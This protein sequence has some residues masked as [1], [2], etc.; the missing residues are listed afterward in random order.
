MSHFHLFNSKFAHAQD[1]WVIKVHDHEQ[2][3]A[4]WFQLN[5]IQTNNSDEQFVFSASYFNALNPAKENRQLSQRFP[6]SRCTFHFSEGEGFR[7]SSEAISMSDHSCSG[8]ISTFHDVMKWNI[9]WFADPDT[10]FQYFSPRSFYQRKHP[11]LKF[12]TPNPLLRAEGKISVGELDINL[13]NVPGIQSHLWGD[14]KMNELTWLQCNAFE[15]TDFAELEAVSF[16]PFRRFPVNPVLSVLRLNLF[17][18]QFIFNSPS[19]MLQVQSRHNNRT[20]LLA[21][22]TENIR[23]QLQLRYQEE[24]LSY[25]IY[26]GMNMAYTGIAGMQ[27]VFSEKYNRE[28]V[29]QQKLT[30]QNGADFLFTSAQ[31]DSSLNPSLSL[32]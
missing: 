27:I 23:I 24:F 12:F 32:Q 30:S 18:Q 14:P 26:P 29:T 11:R 17:Q 22:E 7:F 3:F 2:R 1:I 31:N 10:Q 13:N 25:Q 6:S 19:D 9:Q 15:E 20:Y 28:W 21:A 4:F 5:R 16:R 8:S